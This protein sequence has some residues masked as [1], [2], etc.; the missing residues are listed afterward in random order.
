VHA[1]EIAH[2]SLLALHLFG[3]GDGPI[4]FQVSDSYAFKAGRNQA[5]VQKSFAH[6]ANTDNGDPDFLFQ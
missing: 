1:F 4:D 5:L 2:D 6:R 3:K